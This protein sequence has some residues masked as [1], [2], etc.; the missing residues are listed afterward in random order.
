MAMAGVRKSK[1]VRTIIV[2]I[3]PTIGAHLVS[4]LSDVGVYFM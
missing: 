4:V 3:D 1:T 2:F